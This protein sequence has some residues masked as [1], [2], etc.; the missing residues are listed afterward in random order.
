MSIVMNTCTDWRWSA[1]DLDG[2]HV[3]VGSAARMDQTNRMNTCCE[4]WAGPGL[5]PNRGRTLGIDLGDLASIHID[6]DQA[7]SAGF[8]IG[9][10][11]SYTVEDEASLVAG[12]ASVV[13]GV[14]IGTRARV[15]RPGSGIV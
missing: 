10:C 6:V 4:S 1:E 8:D 7:A 14:V 12:R 15:A 13:V 9:K 5:L 2:I 11:K 3:D